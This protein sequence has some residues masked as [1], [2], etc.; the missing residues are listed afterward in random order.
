[1]LQR[2]SAIKEVL[3]ASEFSLM[4]NAQPGLDLD[5]TS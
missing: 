2:W 3:A 5:R 4:L 1:M